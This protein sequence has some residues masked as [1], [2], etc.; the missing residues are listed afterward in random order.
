MRFVMAMVTMGKC[1]IETNILKL[2]RSIIAAISGNAFCHTMELLL[3]MIHVTKKRQ[4]TVVCS[5]H[6]FK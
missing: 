4:I 1:P 5:V 2:R 6:G 3:M